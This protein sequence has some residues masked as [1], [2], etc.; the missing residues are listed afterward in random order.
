M[1]GQ[2]SFHHEYK[3]LSVKQM[4]DFSTRLVSE[5]D[6]ISGLDAIGWE[7]QFM[8]IF[9]L[10]GDSQ[11]STHKS[12]RLSDSVL[13]AWKELQIRNPTKLGRKGWNGSHLLKLQRF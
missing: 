9:V 11:S 4:F 8:E 6:E 1:P 7:N 5:Q 3:D 13:C 10:I 12:L 2:L